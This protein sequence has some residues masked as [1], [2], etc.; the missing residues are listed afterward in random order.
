MG[1]AQQQWQKPGVFEAF[2]GG[3]TVM[4]TGLSTALFLW[5]Y[6]IASASFLASLTRCSS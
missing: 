6:F 5:C 3:L 4:G 2:C 1:E